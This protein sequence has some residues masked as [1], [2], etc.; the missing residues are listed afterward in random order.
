MSTTPELTLETFIILPF[1]LEWS[2]G[3]APPL[4]HVPMN[5]LPLGLAA[6]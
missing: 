3:K 4:A 1:Q 2:D 6:H 5:S